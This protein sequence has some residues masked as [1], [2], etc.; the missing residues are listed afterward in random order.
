[1]TTLNREQPRLDDELRAMLAESNPTREPLGP[2]RLGRGAKLALWGL[3]LYVL[4]MLGLVGLKF[5]QMAG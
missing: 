3:R 2:M 4:G 5:L 1:M